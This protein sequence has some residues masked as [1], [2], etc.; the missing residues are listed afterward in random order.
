MKRSPYPY[1]SGPVDT[2]PLEKIVP[3]AVYEKGIALRDHFLPEMLMCYSDYRE[4]LQTGFLP[5]DI[6][7]LPRALKEKSIADIRHYVATLEP[8]PDRAAFGQSVRAL[9]KAREEPPHEFARRL[10]ASHNTLCLLE[11]GKET[12]G[13]HW[14]RKVPQLLGASTMQ[15]VIEDAKPHLD[16]CVS[17]AMSTRRHDLPKMAWCQRVAGGNV[18]GRDV[19]TEPEGPPSSAILPATANPWAALLDSAHATDQGGKPGRLGGRGRK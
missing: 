16:A 18:A 5:K 15:Q 7:R 13:S 8:L 6:E 9:R 12:V 1:P 10:G 2:L 14:L 11:N 17:E 4:R 19:G 3:I